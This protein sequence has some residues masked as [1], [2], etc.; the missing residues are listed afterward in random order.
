MRHLDKARLLAGDEVV[1]SPVQRACSDQTFELPTG[2]YAAMAIMFVGF[3][4]VLSLSFSSHM[5]VSFGVISAFLAMFFGVPSL[6][7]H[8]GDLNPE[9]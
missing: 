1:E 4:A 7:P 3:V 2:I 6:F 8:M 9:C 5:A